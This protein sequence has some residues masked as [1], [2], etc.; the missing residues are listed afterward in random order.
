MRLIIVLLNDALT[1][2]ELLSIRRTMRPMVM[3]H[4]DFYELKKKSFVSKYYSNHSS[5]K[6]EENVNTVRDS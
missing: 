3:A 5:G 6:T 2:A 1:I 4:S